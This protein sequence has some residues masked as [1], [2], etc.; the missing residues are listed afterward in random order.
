[1]MNNRFTRHAPLVMGMVILM[2]LLASMLPA[3]GSTSPSADII[4]EAHLFIPNAGYKGI[5]KNRL[6]DAYKFGRKDEFVYVYLDTRKVRSFSWKIQHI[7]KKTH[8]DLK[9]AEIRIRAWLKMRHI[10]LN[11]WFLLSR[12]THRRGDDRYEHTIMFSRKTPNGVLLRNSIILISMDSYGNFWNYSYANSP[13]TISTKPA[14]SKKQLI[15][16]AISAA[17]LKNAKVVTYKLYVADRYNGEKPEIQ[18]LC[19][20]VELQGDITNPGVCGSGWA[21]ITI[22][23]HSGDVISD[24]RH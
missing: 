13:L 21:E 8:V 6:G 10:D 17:R 4:R 24:M 16:K 5:V 1:M 7:K 2:S 14:F 12:E 3:H 11:G 15:K 20:E 9:T 19:A 22:D 18:T 23:A